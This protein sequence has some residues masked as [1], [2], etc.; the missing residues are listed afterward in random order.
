MKDELAGL[1]GGNFWVTQKRLQKRWKMLGCLQSL[2]CMT[3]GKTCH[4]VV[5]EG[6][7]DGPSVVTPES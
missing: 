1:T 3:S 6:K 2:I 5:C 7:M 4:I